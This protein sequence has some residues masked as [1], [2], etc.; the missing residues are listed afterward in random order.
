MLCAI[1]SIISSILSGVFVAHTPAAMVA[2]GHPETSAKEEGRER[3]EWPGSMQ[4]GIYFHGDGFVCWRGRKLLY[5]TY[6]HRY[7]LYL[8]I[9]SYIK[10]N[11]YIYIHTCK[12][13][14][15]I[16]APSRAGRVLIESVHDLL[17]S[18]PIFLPIS[19]WC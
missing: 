19:S 17:P 8:F 14:L 18:M 16:P 4:M 5:Y 10:F 7:I 2:A 1:L 9:S 3:N 11:I 6:T 13:I 15:Q 12:W